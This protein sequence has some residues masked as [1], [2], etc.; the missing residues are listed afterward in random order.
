MLHAN[1][2]SRHHRRFQALQQTQLA[3]LPQAR[4][5]G[6][7]CSR[8]ALMWVATVSFRIDMRGNDYYFTCMYLG[9][10][11]VQLHFTNEPITLMN[12]PITHSCISKSWSK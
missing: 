3:I 4:A 12:R 9:D 2:E 11:T 1:H 8:Y 5:C 10:S 6:S 7:C